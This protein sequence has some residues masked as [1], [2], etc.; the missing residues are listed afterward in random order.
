ME[1]EQKQTATTDPLVWLERRKEALRHITFP[2]NLLLRDFTRMAR[3]MAEHLEVE[4]PA[5]REVV[6]EQGMLQEVLIGIIDAHHL[7]V[8]SYSCTCGKC[9]RVFPPDQSMTGDVVRYRKGVHT[10]VVLEQ[11]P[12]ENEWVRVIRPFIGDNLL[13]E[14][15]QPT[16]VTHLR[17]PRWQANR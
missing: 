10:I 13:G 8:G 2:I 1:R 12:E 5:S 17:T 11:E 9:Q 6:R 4:R 7:T 15:I 16:T 3:E 14:Q